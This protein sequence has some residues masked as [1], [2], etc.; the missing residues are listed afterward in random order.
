MAT[1]AYATCFFFR[2]ASADPR[3]FP[4]GSKRPVSFT[5]LGA[6]GWCATRIVVT[7]WAD[8]GGSIVGFA[9]TVSIK[10]TTHFLQELPGDSGLWELEATFARMPAPVFKPLG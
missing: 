2:S 1:A 10:I 9:G 7:G 6:S 3:R 4:S 5:N 8:E